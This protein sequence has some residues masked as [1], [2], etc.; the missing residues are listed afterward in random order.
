MARAGDPLRPIAPERGAKRARDALEQGRLAGAVRPDDG[1]QGAGFDGAVEVMHRGA[2]AIAE[3]QIVEGQGIGHDQAQA[4]AA[5]IPAMITPA[6]ASR[7][8]ADSRSTESP[9]VEGLACRGLS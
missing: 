3:R 2:P 1:Q 9:G 5:Q 8:L 4:T 7:T 6:P